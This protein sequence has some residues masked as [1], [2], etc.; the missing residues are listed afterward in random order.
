MKVSQNKGGKISII[1]LK[2]L[3]EVSLYF[4]DVDWLNA[5]DFYTIK[6]FSF[7]KIDKEGKV[8]YHKNKAS[9]F[10]D[11]IK[12]AVQSSLPGDKIILKDFKVIR[13]GKVT[14]LKPLVLEVI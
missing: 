11:K 13:H 2:R 10:N 12:K 4:D 7:I 9:G 6:S 8:F 3:E 1:T 5:L 14:K